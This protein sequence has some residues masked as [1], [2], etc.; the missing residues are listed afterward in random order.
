MTK[1]EFEKLAG[2]VSNDNFEAINFVYTF[3]PAISET[4]GKEQ[5]SVIFGN[6]G[7]RLISDMMPTAQKSKALEEDIRKKSLELEAL[8]ENLA[9]LRQ[10]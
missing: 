8:K 7:M 10:G 2:P 3:H 6:F 9:A 4:N 1:Q 5:I